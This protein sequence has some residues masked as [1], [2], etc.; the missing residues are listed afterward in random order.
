MVIRMSEPGNEDEGRLLYGAAGVCL[1]VAAYKVLPALWKPP[2]PN[3]P[4]WSRFCGALIVEMIIAGALVAIPLICWS[5][6]KPKWTYWL[7]DRFA[8]KMERH[9]LIVFG[10]MSL[11]GFGLV[12]LDWF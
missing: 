12:V 10:L 7:Y 3:T 11:I 4:L 1:L 8:E 6:A 9:V 5:I 2:R